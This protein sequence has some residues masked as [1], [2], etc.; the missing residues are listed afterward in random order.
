MRHEKTFITPAMAE[1]WLSKKWDRQRPF[2]EGHV[3]R[4]MSDL[5]SGKFHYGPQAIAFDKRGRLVD[6]QHRLEA[7]RRS[8]QGFHS[9]V[10][11]DLDDAVIPKLGQSEGWNLAALLNLHNET[12]QFG[13]A[14]N[15]SVAASV[16]SFLF[17]QI[18]GR[19]RRP[20]D[21]EALALIRHFADDILWSLDG[22]AAKVLSRV[23]V[24]SAFVIMH[25]ARSATFEIFADKVRTGAGL[26]RNDPALTLR[27][28]IMV[29][30][31]MKQD[32]VDWQF[33][34]VL[35]AGEAHVMNEKLHRL[36][37]AK[38]PNGAVRSQMDFFLGS[39]TKLA[40][41]LGLLPNLDHQLPAVESGSQSVEVEARGTH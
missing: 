36:L 18:T 9:L 40:D 27:D 23:P 28:Y 5:L 30:E 6:G 39:S 17:K 10:A 29:G 20:T 11:Y 33:Y 8:G 12:R 31:S 41:R 25:N 1:E 38:D 37:P 14:H 13:A 16:S 2:R 32:A 7:A 4:L 19:R 34:K 3:Q 15:I 22:C 35:R 21:D 26:A 24:R